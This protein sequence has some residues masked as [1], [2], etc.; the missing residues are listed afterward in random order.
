MEIEVRRD[1]EMLANRFGKTQYL[2]GRNKNVTVTALLNDVNHPFY[3]ATI[4]QATN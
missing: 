1:Y 4:W 2:W 3:L